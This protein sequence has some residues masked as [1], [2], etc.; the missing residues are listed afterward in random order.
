MQHDFKNK[1]AVGIGAASEADSGPTLKP[2]TLNGEH[3]YLLPS[4]NEEV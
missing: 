3:E 4:V 2:V 1:S